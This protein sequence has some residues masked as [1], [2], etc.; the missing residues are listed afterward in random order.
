MPA[1]HALRCTLLL[2]LL[3]GLAACSPP[4]RQFDIRDQPLTCDDANRLT[5]RTLEAMRFKVTA[6][7]PAAPGQRGTIKATR[8]ASGAED[9]SQDATVTVVCAASGVTIDASEDYNWLNQVDFKRSFYHAFV[10]VQTMHSSSAELEKENLAGTAPESQ[11]RR[12]LKVVVQP[13]RG[14]AGKLDFPF[15]LDAAGVLP[16]RIE[17]TNLT[18]RTYALD[19]SAIRLT[20]ADRTRVA[21]LSA[22]DAAGLVTGAARGTPPQPLTSLSRSAVADALA[23]R[24][25]T[26]TEIAPGVARVGFLY[27]PLA[28]YVAARVVLTDQASGEDEGVSV[29]F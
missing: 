7:E 2:G 4:I 11:Q 22:A 5:Y 20:R 27:F 13:Q 29:E 6:F 23:Q 12:D 17:I 9:R 21:P 28:Q 19:P 10:N 1:P 26:A 16:I 25:F 3:A 14:Q 8:A 15:D 18:T 24:Q